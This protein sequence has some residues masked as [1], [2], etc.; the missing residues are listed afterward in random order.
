MF[1]FY[2]VFCQAN[3][4]LSLQER[5]SFTYPLTPPTILQDFACLT[6]LRYKKASKATFITSI[7]T[8]AAFVTN[9]GSQI[10]AL[11]LFGIFMAMIVC[12][13]WLLV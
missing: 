4:E 3:I 6:F 1:V 8:A 11:R 7:T 5:L 9:I 12:I 10:P 13:N 2:D